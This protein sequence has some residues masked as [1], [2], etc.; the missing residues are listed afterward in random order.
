MDLGKWLFQAKGRTFDQSED[1]NPSHSSTPLLV[2][3]AHPEVQLSSAA[4]T[5]CGWQ[6]VASDSHKDDF[7]R[8]SA[9]NNSF[10]L[11]CIERVSV[12]NVAK[13]T[14]I[15]LVDRRSST[16][17]ACPPCR[18]DQETVRP[19]MGSIP[20]P[21][22]SRSPRP[23]RSPGP[24]TDGSQ[25]P[26]LPQRQRIAQAAR[27][28]NGEIIPRK[29]KLASR[30][31]FTQELVKITPNCLRQRRIL[32]D[33]VKVLLV[34]WSHG[35]YREMQDNAEAIGNMLHNSYHFEI[36]KVPLSNDIPAINL[37]LKM[38]AAME[39]LSKASKQ[40][41]LI[42]FYC[43]HGVSD[44]DGR[45]LWKPEEET[46]VEL[47]WD[48]SQ[49]N[50]LDADCDILFLIDCCQASAMIKYGMK[51]KRR[52]ELLGA[53]SATEQALANE[54]FSF[55]TALIQFLQSADCL[56]EGVSIDDLGWDL[57]NPENLTTKYGLLKE[58]GYVYH[59]GR[60]KHL[61]SIFLN[62]LTQTPQKS[63]Q[64][65]Q[66]TVEQLNARANKVIL[67]ALMLTDSAIPSNITEWS[68]MISVAP[69]EV[70]G[71]EFEML[72]VE[73][74][75]EVLSCVETHA[76][77][78]GSLVVIV[79]MPVWLW[80][81]LEPNDSYHP[82]GFVRSGNLLQSLEES[83]ADA[84]VT[85]W[86]TA[87][88]PYEGPRKDDASDS[89]YESISTYSEQPASIAHEPRPSIMKVIEEE[90]GHFK[91]LQQFSADLVEALSS[92]FSDGTK[93]LYTSVR[94][95][96][97][98]FQDDDLGVEHE[99]RRLQS[100]LTDVYAFDTE[101]WSIPS[102][103]SQVAIS[104]KLLQFLQDYD[105][106]DTLLIVYYGGH[107]YFDTERRSYWSA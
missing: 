89:A 42:I 1:A 84:I 90:E 71:I 36:E 54:D 69:H 29:P 107:G 9:I 63:T 41:L 101:H 17:A 53:T 45:L 38:Y 11:R 32:Y 37:N 56:M 57:K 80:D 6:S 31:Q 33:R 73:E 93:S 26:G 18:H 86:R 105:A 88:N 30:D 60:N 2:V 47:R 39:D 100:V 10:S 35:Q 43:G 40:N 85:K 81:Y 16:W 14:A 44:T 51:W 13:K 28:V 20:S 104:R 103:R 62:P 50:L 98:S 25:A 12:D 52:C 95:L 59:S 61:S 72:S 24:T 99:V 22:E 64:A 58:P 87:I 77:F 97:L 27:P 8:L 34:Y 48:T 49:D 82:I 70:S 66:R 76:V 55:T 15:N 83:P 78:E 94:V 75:N 23:S 67:M 91:G 4:R 7:L 3:E 46:S 74:Y 106:E 5:P 102:S 92:V 68:K 79:S 65:I 21:V 96:L 19:K